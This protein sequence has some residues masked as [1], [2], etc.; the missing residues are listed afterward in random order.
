MI[1]TANRIW[2]PT[3]EQ[4]WQTYKN[5]KSYQK[6]EV[7]YSIADEDN[8]VKRMKIIIPSGLTYLREFNDTDD[9]ISKYG[10]NTNITVRFK[11]YFDADR[12][13][14]FVPHILCIRVLDEE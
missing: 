2:D 12:I 13:I 9:I 14:L 8:Q 3:E 11:D 5:L 10:V 1:K 6:L 7:W 4:L